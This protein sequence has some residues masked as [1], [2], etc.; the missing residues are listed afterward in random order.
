MDR[1]LRRSFALTAL[2]SLAVWPT[3]ALGER[4]VAIEPYLEQL[5]LP[6]QHVPTSTSELRFVAQPA[7]Q[8]GIDFVERLDWDRPRGE[9]FFTGYACGGIAVGDVDGNGLPDLVFAGGADRMRLY[10]QHLPWK[11]KEAA[12]SAGLAHRSEDTWSTGATL[13]DVD[14]DGDLDLYVCNYDEANCL[15]IN[16]GDGTFDERAA[17]YG[18]DIVDASLIGSVADYDRDG[19]LDI[20]LAANRYL[21]EKRFHPREL[22]YWRNGREYLRPGAEKY[23]TIRRYRDRPGQLNMWAGR[24]N[25]LLRNEGT[26][27]KFVD[28]SQHMPSGRADTL[29]AT[30]W[31]YDHDGWPDLYVAN[32]LSAPDRLLHNQGDGTFADVALQSLPHL[33][34]QAMGSSAGDINNDGLVDFLV[35]DMSFRTHFKDKV[36]MGDMSTKFRNVSVFPHDQL[37]RNAL[38]INSGTPKFQEAAYL[39]GLASTDWTW[40]A[41]LADFDSDGRLDAYFTNGS[42]VN[43]G[44]S[45]GLDS[46]DSSDGVIDLGRLRQRYRSEP[47]VLEQNLIFQNQGDLHFVDRSKAWGIAETGMSFAAVH[48]DLDRDGNLDLVVANLDR[49]PTVYRNE[50]QAS[51]VVIELHGNRSN[52][53]GVGA[54][55]EIETDAGAQVRQIYPVSGFQSCQEAAAHFGLGGN[56]LI[57]RLTVRWPSGTEQVFENLPAAA[58]YRVSEAAISHSS[59]P[60]PAQTPLFVEALGSEIVEH[61]E[62]PFDDFAQQPLLPN[63]LSQLGP[64]MAWDDIDGDGDQD[65]FL[66]EGKHWMGMLYVNHGKLRFEP[67]PQIAFANDEDAEDSAALFFDANGDGHVDLFVGS[68]SVEFE[69]GD[70]RLRD[71]LYLG[72]GQG[73]FDQTTDTLPD[74]RRNTGAVAASDIDHDGDLDLFVGSRSVPGDYPIAPQHALLINDGGRFVDALDS[75]SLALGGVGLGTAAKWCVVDSDGWDDLLLATDWGPVRL[76]R[77]VSGKLVE[78][79]NTSGLAQWTGWWQSLAAADVDNDGDVDLVAGNF[80]LNTKYRASTAKPVIAYYG[81]YGESGRRNLIEASYEDDVLFPIRGRSC[82]SAAMPYLAEQYSSYQQFARASLPEIYTPK[83]LAASQRFEVNTLASSCFLNDGNG[84]F[85]R[86]DLPREL[87]L[88]PVFAI[89]IADID[90]DGAVDLCC[91]QNFFGPQRETGPMDGGL[92]VIALG[93]GNGTFTAVRPDHAGIAVADD[94]KSIAMVDLDGDD[95]EDVCVASN[96]GRWRVFCHPTSATESSQL[97]EPSYHQDWIRLHMRVAEQFFAANQ[98]AQSLSSLR[99]VLKIDPNHSRASLM[100]ASVLRRE[101]RYLDTAK[102]LDRLERNPTVD[103]AQLHAERGRLFFDLQQY[104]PAAESLNIAVGLRPDDASIHEQL[105]RVRQVQGN[106]RAAR[107]HYLQSGLNERVHEIDQIAAVAK[108]AFEQGVLAE[109]EGRDEEAIMHFEKSRRRHASPEVLRRLA[110]VLLTTEQD[111][112]RDPWLGEQL[113]IWA[114]EPSKATESE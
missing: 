54:E 14:G 60:A 25:R 64:P 72:T 98:P 4:W 67:R 5:S 29:S 81:E 66:G 96:A 92:G 36:F 30:W 93:K 22:F 27:R 113:R 85:Q 20:Y 12:H 44:N 10:L 84:R 23:F 34:W 106:L 73:G 87:Q 65:C 86:V 103:P 41:K 78:A 43:L 112:L 21:D 75:R 47:P 45:T 32:D 51:G 15:Y 39:S 26:G 79:T 99:R 110:E 107:A 100:L 17:A 13:F 63:R 46:P 24:R 114:N 83:C 37:M 42:P 68:G 52:H 16:R 2:V 35:A 1:Y 3:F 28:V 94:T 95:R 56:K 70:P 71:R 49:P 102:L 111:E 31:D 53:L 69:Q 33:P 55:I 108:V 77:N 6:I 104:D 97:I 7:T 9:L 74:I 88:A 8:T 90:D 58:R 48:A 62:E 76:Y 80:G 89:A 57:K 101:R 50:S 91:G 11:F 109:A 19:D 40:S 38:F 61:H 18:L 82:S 59:V 105:G